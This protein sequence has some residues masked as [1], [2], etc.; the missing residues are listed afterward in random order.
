MQ[1]IST[2]CTRR[3][4]TGSSTAGHIALREGSSITRRRSLQ[5]L[6]VPALAGLTGAAWP[7]LSAAA[8]SEDRF[9][10]LA[11]NGNSNCSTEFMKSIAAMSDNARLQGSCCSPMDRERYISQTRGLRRYAAIGD[12]PPDPYDIAAGLAKRLMARY[13]DALSRAEQ[14]AYQYAM[15]HS[16]EQGPCCCQ[17]WR[18]QV[19]GGLGKVLIQKHHFAGEQVVEVWDL[20]NGCGGA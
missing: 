14:A 12:I 1:E 13:D 4:T 7:G 5:L 15:D 3:S 8:D 10:Y 16:K 17:C 11:A 9:S 20:S 18:W 19:Y 2:C 6:F